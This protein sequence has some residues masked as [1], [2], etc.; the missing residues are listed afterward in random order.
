MGCGE[1]CVQALRAAVE[2]V[3]GYGLG[4]ARDTMVVK[5]DS[6]AGDEQ[7]VWVGNQW[8]TSQAPGRPRN[9]DLLYFYP[10]EFD[11]PGDVKQVRHESNRSK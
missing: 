3:L 10:L 9:H 4:S 11:E 6:S 1:W 5:V 2:L 7:Y 8:D